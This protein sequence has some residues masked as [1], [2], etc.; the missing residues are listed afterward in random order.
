M[1]A[2][3]EH[4]HKAVAPRWDP[5]FPY[6]HPTAMDSMGGIAAPLLAGFAITFS[7]IVMTSASSFRWPGVVL[8]L[9]TLAI[10]A[11]IAAVQFSF[12]TRLYAVTP[13]QIEEW[14]E[15]PERVRQRLRREQRYHRHHYKLWAERAAL[16][17]NAGILLFL[18]G[19]TLALV[20][21]S[22]LGNWR[23][24]AFAVA[25]AGTVLELGWVLNR[26]FGLGSARSSADLSSFDPAPEVSD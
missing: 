21:P 12:Q 24:V 19:F 2:M 13:S 17:Y 23:L 20:P 15:K 6:G 16:A 25:A 8:A 11:L 22:S 10:L 9:L 5:P 3:T 26:Q 7:V 1:G 4:T 14:W 18:G